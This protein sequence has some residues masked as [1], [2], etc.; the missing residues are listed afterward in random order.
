MYLLHLIHLLL[1]IYPDKPDYS[2]M[3]SSTIPS[4]LLGCFHLFHP[5]P[6]AQM[7]AM[8]F[9]M[10]K[11]EPMALCLKYKNYVIT[12]T[13]NETAYSAYFVKTNNLQKIHKDSNYKDV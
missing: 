2:G 8:L 10:R 6:S 13:N 12:F 11:K 4:E 1:H 9:H 3:L 7:L 5:M